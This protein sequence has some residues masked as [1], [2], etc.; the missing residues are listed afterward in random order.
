MINCRKV[1]LFN[2]D[3]KQLKRQRRGLEKGVEKIDLPEI[4]TK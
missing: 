4:I 3:M 1:P 2:H